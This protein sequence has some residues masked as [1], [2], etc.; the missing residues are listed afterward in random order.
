MINTEEFLI[1]EKEVLNQWK[2]LLVRQCSDHKYTIYSGFVS[3]IL[4]KN[5]VYRKVSIVAF[6]TL[7]FW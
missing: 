3:V 6:L 7:G 5:K 2:G 1:G 4:T